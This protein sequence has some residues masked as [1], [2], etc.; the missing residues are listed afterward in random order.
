[1]NSRNPNVSVF[2]HREAENMI[3]SDQ[4]QVCNMIEEYKIIF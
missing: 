1:M 2:L 3:G 4:M